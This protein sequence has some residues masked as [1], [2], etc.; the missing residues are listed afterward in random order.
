MV[1]MR[2][3]GL[4]ASSTVLKRI[5]HRDTHP[6]RLATGGQITRLGTVRTGDRILPLAHPGHSGK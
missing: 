6:L 4:P 2:Q 3:P 1:G 5:A